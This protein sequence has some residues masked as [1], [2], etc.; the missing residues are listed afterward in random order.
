MIPAYVGFALCLYPILKTKSEALSLG[1]VG[2][3]LV[4]AAFHLIAVVS[5]SLFLT[6]SDQYIQAG[7]P[8]TFHSFAEILRIGRDLIN[9]VGMILASSM[10]DVLLFYLLYQTGLVPRWLSGW[11]LIGTA[12]AMIA[13]LLILFQVTNVV[14]T[15]YLGL[16]VPIALQGFIFAGWLIFKGFDVKA[17]KSESTMFVIG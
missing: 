1:F 4:A 3:R 9:H 13:S 12:L 16:N 8:E 14:T 6:V 17:I 10:G 2:F 15:L 11:G 5:L 7:E